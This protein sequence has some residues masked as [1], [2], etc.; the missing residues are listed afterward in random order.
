MGFTPW[1]RETFPRTIPVIEAIIPRDRIWRQREML[2]QD[3]T[4]SQLPVA[5]DTLALDV[6]SA[7]MAMGALGL[8]A[9]VSYPFPSDS[10]SLSR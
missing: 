7:R 8:S 4:V 1:D 9:E 6:S 10:S 3:Q 2:V 5:T